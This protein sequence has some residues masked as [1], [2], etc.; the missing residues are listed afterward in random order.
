MLKH[1][2]LAVGIAYVLRSMFLDFVKQ[3]EKFGRSLRHPND[4]IQCPHSLFVKKH[5]CAN[6]STESDALEISKRRLKFSPTMIN[7]VLFG[8]KE[9]HLWEKVE[10]LHETKTFCKNKI[11]WMHFT[12][13]VNANR[14]RRNGK[15]CFTLHD[16]E[17]GHF[18]YEKTVCMY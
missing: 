9:D 5:L 11:G 4:D 12:C 15:N 6:C 2:L 1:F 16:T 3:K 14:C 17:N 8:S 13:N 10:D 18:Y 7:G